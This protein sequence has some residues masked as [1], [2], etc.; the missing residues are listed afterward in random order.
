[1]TSVL[2]L[3]EAKET[4]AREVIER[5][6]EEA[7]RIV[8]ELGEAEE[9]LE[10]LVIARET[11]AEVLGGPAGA[12]R[13]AAVNG[14]DAVVAGVMVVPCRREGVSARVLPEDYQRV[15]AVLD[16]EASMGGVRARALTVALGREEVPAKIECVRSM[17]KRLVARGWAAE[18]T[19]GVFTPAAVSKEPS[20]AA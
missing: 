15:M 4:A 18:E 12:R 13:Q 1:M 7:D 11:V 2:G 5:L 10:R 20:A 17:A 16:A 9:R 6:R 14:A 3:L 19:P 8:A